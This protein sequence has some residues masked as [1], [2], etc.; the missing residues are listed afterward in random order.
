MKIIIAGLGK[1]GNTLARQL[2]AENDYD[3][4][5]VDRNAQVLQT[6]VEKYDVL[7]VQGNCAAMTTLVD[8]GVKD[9]DLLIAVTD[10]DEMNLLCC[11]TAHSLNPRIHT[12]ARIRNPE[13]SDQVYKMRDLLALSMSVNPEKQAAIEIERLLKYP[14][15]LKREPFAKGRMEIVELRVEPGSKLCNVA[16]NNLVDAVNCKVLVCAVTRGGECIMPSGNFVLREGDK[17][18]VTSESNNLTR[19][20]KNLGII[21]RKVNRVLICG[22]GRVSY[23]LSQLLLKSGIQVQ[24][25]ENNPERCLMLAE[26]LSEADIIQGDASSQ[27]L[28][29]SEGLFS[30]DA[31]VSLTGLDELNVIIALYGSRHGVPQI[32]TKVGHLEPNG[33]LDTLPVGSLV[34]PKELC[35]NGIVRYVRAMR[36]QT[37][38]AITTHRIAGG[39]AE[40]LEFRV[41]ENTR[42]RGEPLKSLKIKPNILLVSINHASHV[43]LPNGDSCYQ[44]GDGVV[45]VT[46]GSETIYQ[47]NDIF[48]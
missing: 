18:F 22:G 24:I 30:C 3:L 19:L 29:E 17:I 16:L 15:F 47:L 12:I 25:I 41:D 46:N 6:V 31:L 44:T 42:H 27:A 23:Y 40:A 33:I 4:T 35:S 28:L 10:A 38:A 32:I 8:A 36:N 20:L 43:E 13:Y 1:V 34:C 7:G 39:R 5:V 21:T 2:A 14:G 37:G 11:V 9:A 48:A 45:I 26:Q